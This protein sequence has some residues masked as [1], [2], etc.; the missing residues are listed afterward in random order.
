M[1]GAG[2]EDEFGF[3]WSKIVRDA[4]QKMQILKRQEGF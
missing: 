3:V 2:M 4:G 1:G